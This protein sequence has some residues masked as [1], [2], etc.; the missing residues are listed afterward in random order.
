MT[1][2]EQVASPSRGLYIDRHLCV[3][4]SEPD[5]HGKIPT[6]LACNKAEVW[7]ETFFAFTVVLPSYVQK[8]KKTICYQSRGFCSLHRF[9]VM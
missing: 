1:S 3:I 4:R 5:L 2:T 9:L 8:E 7:N 6:F